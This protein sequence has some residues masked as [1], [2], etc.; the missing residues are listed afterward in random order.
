MS[1]FFDECYRKMRENIYHGKTGR[2]RLKDGQRFNAEYDITR[3]QVSNGSQVWIQVGYAVGLQVKFLRDFWIAGNTSL[4]QREDAIKVVTIEGPP[5]V[6]AGKRTDGG[7]PLSHPCTKF[8]EDLGNLSS[9]DTR[10]KP[11]MHCCTGFMIEILLWLE[12]DLD[13][14]FDLY[15]V[16]D[17]RYGAYNK[18]N[19][20]VEWNDPRSDRR[21]SRNSAS[22]AGSYF[23]KDRSC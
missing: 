19:K 18:K 15:L 17:G 12:R 14:Q 9:K 10:R 13:V 2:F 3:V 20:K 8:V 21:E 5:L 11:Q 7:C 6:L 16:E 22:P 4:F 1:S 23:W